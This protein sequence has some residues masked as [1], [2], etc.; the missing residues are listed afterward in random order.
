MVSH[1]TRVFE[2]LRGERSAALRAVLEAALPADAEWRPVP[3]AVFSVK[4]EDVVL[5]CYQSGKV[6][7]QG[8]NLEEFLSRYLPGFA[9]DA[10]C[11]AAESQLPI[12]FV[13]L[14]SDETG[15]GDYF[16]PLVVA[17]VRLDPAHEARLRQ[18]GVTDSKQLSDKR[19]QMLAGLL[20]REVSFEFSQLM[21]EAYN[22]AY[23]RAKSVNRLLAD[24]HARAL[25]RLHA[26]CPDAQG[27][28]VDQFA[29]PG[30]LQAALARECPDHPSLLQVT[31]GERHVAVAAA[32]ILARA[33]F[34]D[35]LRAC[36]EACA[37]ELAKGAGAPVDEAARKVRAIGGRELLA[38]VAKMHFKNTDKSEGP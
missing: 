22:Q 17:A 7:A 18:A 27:I 32:S 2:G 14:G 29:D 33:R 1:E 10:A 26:R 3:H 12:E 9:A 23:A 28:V 6:V 4:A 38:K 13:T 5:T 11:A 31:K 19:V 15:K 30:T 36:S 21:P 16:G 8:R 34:L 25:A 37:V 35:G 24:M 20:E